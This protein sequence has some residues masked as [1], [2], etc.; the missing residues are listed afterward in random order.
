M[1]P[2]CG[3]RGSSAVAPISAPTETTG[4]LSDF[5]KSPFQVA[6]GK[7]AGLVFWIVN[8]LLTGFAGSA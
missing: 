2:S 3:R 6:E 4:E 7:F 8:N 5:V 1:K